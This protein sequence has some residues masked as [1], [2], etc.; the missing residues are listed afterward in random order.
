MRWLLWSVVQGRWVAKIVVSDIGA[1]IMGG[2]ALWAFLQMVGRTPVTFSWS[3]LT[4]I[5][6]HY[7]LVGFHDCNSSE[8]LRWFQLDGWSVMLDAA[9]WR[10]DLQACGRTVWVCAV[11]GTWS[12]C[13]AFQVSCRWRLPFFTFYL[14]LF[15][16]FFLLL[17]WVLTI[18]VVLLPF[19]FV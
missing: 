19:S 18:M 10:V 9:R 3:G 5:G 17:F 13:G 16:V 15:N 2:M 11:V 7:L 1:W 12:S 8:F 6:K 4:G 14:F